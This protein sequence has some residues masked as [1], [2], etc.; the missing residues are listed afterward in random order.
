M[1]DLLLDDLY[2]KIQHQASFVHSYLCKGTPP[3]PEGSCFDPEAEVKESS[4]HRGTSL[5]L[6]KLSDAHEEHRT[7]PG[8]ETRLRSLLKDAGR[9]NDMHLRG[10]FNF[11]TGGIIAL[12]SAQS[13]SMLQSSITCKL[14]GSWLIL[15]QVPSRGAQ[16]RFSPISRMLIC[17]LT[18]YS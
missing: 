6:A 7:S 16:T 15:D 8:R 12:E 2:E 5:A 10:Y 14:F 1:P 11:K 17:L 18:R 4:D 3:N 9:L 13:I